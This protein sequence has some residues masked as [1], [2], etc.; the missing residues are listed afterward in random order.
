[1][2][3]F[4][5]HIR[6]HCTHAHHLRDMVS[7]TN[8]K[9]VKMFIWTTARKTA[10]LQCSKHWSVCAKSRIDDLHGY[11]T[12]V[13]KS[14]LYAFTNRGTTQTVT[15]T[16]MHGLQLVHFANISPFSSHSLLYVYSINLFQRSWYIVFQTGLNRDE[17]DCLCSNGMLC[18]LFL[19]IT[20]SLSILSSFVL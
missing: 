10:T 18:E 6:N 16:R 5:D 15:A 8:E 7:P 19:H 11:I 17:F 13:G 4:R 2:N 12:R 20:R 3:Y 1:M 9:I 14:F